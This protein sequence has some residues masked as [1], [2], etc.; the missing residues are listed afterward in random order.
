M[1]DE[2]VRIGDR[3]AIVHRQRVFEFWAWAAY[4][5]CGYSDYG[6]EWHTVVAD[7]HRHVRSH[8]M[9]ELPVTD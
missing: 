5:P 7:A 2:P 4:C 8:R 3:K 1:R 9:D 6:L